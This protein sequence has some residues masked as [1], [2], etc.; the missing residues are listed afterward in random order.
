MSYLLRLTIGENSRITHT[1]QASKQLRRRN[2]RRLKPEGHL[3]LSLDHLANRSFLSNGFLPINS[4]RMA[5]FLNIKLGY[6]C[7]VIYN[8]RQS[9][10]LTQPLWLPDLLG[11]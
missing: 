11:L 4:T 8:D 3:P 7:V 2:I 5:I 10:T 1:E 6:V 9:T